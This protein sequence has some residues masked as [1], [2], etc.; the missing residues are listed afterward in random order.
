MSQ[1]QRC[2]VAV[3]VMGGDHAPS[4]PVAGALEAARSGVA[5]VL[6]VGEQE[7]VRRELAKHSTDGLAVQVVPSQG[8][9][10]EGEHPARALR[11]KPQA[12]VALAAGL[13]K[14]GKADAFVTMGSTGA[15]MTAAVLALGL[16]EGLERPALGGPFLPLAP[17]TSVIDLGSNV[18]C[19]PSQFVS[20][21]AIGSTFARRFLGI[22][23]PRVALL[24]VGAEEG[25]GNRQVREAYPL[26]QAS[27]LNFVGNVEGHD[28][29]LGRADVVVCDGFVGN[30]LLK[31]T[32]GL[33]RALASSI[34]DALEAQLPADILQQL[35]VHVASVTT[36]AERAGGP[37][38]GVDGVAIVGHGRSRA[39][40]VTG[41]IEMAC[42]ML[43]LDV[44]QQMKDEMAQVHQRTGA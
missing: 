10:T 38:F 1:G 37:L 23:N 35:L 39:P 40:A 29:F 4:E 20:F 3:D 32:E 33:G 41:A 17:G 43:E 13:V 7:V 12:S 44:V 16:M 24:S 8:V 18:D 9:I 31:Y 14:Q 2:R 19:R 28:I 36:A 6:L 27:G 25:K 26:L 30:V 11:Q 22:E 42:Q 15:A 21:A 5:Q 34:R